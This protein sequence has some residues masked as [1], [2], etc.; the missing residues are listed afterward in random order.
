MKIQNTTALNTA[1]TQYAK[2][3]DSPASSERLNL[4]TASQSRPDTAETYPRPQIIT[5]K[6]A[7]INSSDQD[8]EIAPSTQSNSDGDTLDLDFSRI[9]RFIDRF[10]WD[11]VPPDNLRGINNF[12]EKS[13]TIFNQDGDRL[14]IH[15]RAAVGYRSSLYGEQAIENTQTPEPITGCSTCE[16]RRYVDRSDDSSVSYQTPTNLNPR[17]AAADIAAHEREHVN[18][19]RARADR[20]GR[21]IVNQTVTI[22]YAMCT[23]CNTLYPSGGTT[24]THSISSADEEQEF[25]PGEEDVQH[26]E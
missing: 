24:R 13:I 20:E 8:F 11:K 1:A 9:K 5:P 21:E 17:T 19:E 3:S 7:I 4:P 22:Q 14:D 6:K 26:I 10:G 16:S 12:R 23:E 18:N 2:F 15:Y 25:I